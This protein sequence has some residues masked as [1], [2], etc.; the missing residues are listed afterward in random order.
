MHSL[1]HLNKDVKNLGLLDTFSA[2]PFENY[3]Q[4]LKRILSKIQISLCNKCAKRHVK[5][6][7]VS[8]CRKQTSMFHKKIYQR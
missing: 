6:N 1:I 5:E 2:F 3:L 8:K 7:A 4:E